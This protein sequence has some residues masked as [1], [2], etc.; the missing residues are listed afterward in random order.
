[1][2]S[3]LRKLH[4]TTKTVEAQQIEQPLLDMYRDEL[5]SLIHI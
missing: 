4:S 3:D 2:E 1:M 5:L